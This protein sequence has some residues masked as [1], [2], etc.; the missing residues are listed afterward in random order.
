M[1]TLA[2]VGA[3]FCGTV[4]AIEFIRACRAPAKLIIVEQTGAFGPGLAYGDQSKSH[5]LNVPAGNMSALHGHPDSFLEYCL[6][7]GLAT[8]PGDFIPRR[9][10]GRYLSSLLDTALSSC[11]ATLSV[12]RVHAEAIEIKACT[13]GATVLLSNQRRLTV[14]HVLLACGNFPPSTPKPFISIKHY[15]GYQDAPWGTLCAPARTLHP[16]DSVLIIGSGLT[17]LDVIS[18]LTEEGHSGK[19]TA[20]SR[21]GL[22]PQVHRGHSHYTEQNADLTRQVMCSVKAT[23][24]TY[25]KTVRRLISDSPRVDWRDIIAALRPCTAQ[26]WARL[27]YAEK[28]RFLRH[29][30]PYWDNHRHRAAPEAHVIFDRLKKSGQLTV[31]KGR[32]LAADVI[33]DKIA[34]TILRTTEHS[35]TVDAFDLVINCTGPN[36]SV[37]SAESALIQQ[38]LNEGLIVSDPMGLGIL[39]N[40]DLSVVTA[41]HTTVTWLSYVGP[42]LKSMFWEATAVPELRQHVSAHA[43]RLA[44]KLCHHADNVE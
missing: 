22:T 35:T 27:P 29:V 41:E 17:A 13:G 15:S 26:L 7:N 8:G 42:M 30:R 14:N 19:I 3:G 24:L 5:V 18:R 39:M 40:K 37:S 44:E 34:C 31:I 38:L 25:I 9:E 28:L 1:R 21:R 23:A 10:Y 43:I 12:E 6:L 32:L 16:S 2:I 36:T 11:G 4:A 20:I 33:D